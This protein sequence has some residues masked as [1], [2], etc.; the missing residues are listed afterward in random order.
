MAKRLKYDATII[1]RDDLTDTLAVFR[2]VPDRPTPRPWFTAGQYYVLGL[3]NDETRALGA[4]QRPMSIAS[5]PEAAG[6]IEFYIR[7]IAHPVSPHSFTHLLWKCKV[8]DR[9][10]MRAVAAGTFTMKDTVAVDDTRLRVLVAAGTGIA[11]F[12]SMIRSEICQKSD[13]DLARWV[14]LHGVS[15]ERD[16][17]YRPELLRVSAVHH[18]KYWATVSRPRE[19]PHWGGDVGRVE[20]FFDPERLPDLE[21]RLGLRPHGFVPDN[22]VVFICGLN[23]T[24]A[25][26]MAR[27]L[28]RAF[29]PDVDRTR[30]ALGVPAE[31]P[32]SLY[33]ERYDVDDVFSDVEG[34]QVLGPLRARMQAALTTASRRLGQI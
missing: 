20:S 30:R 29:V 25:A 15:C 18:L 3:N 2:I 9:I 8:G 33:F 32:S 17:G 16:L 12:V 31:I 28:D 6:P 21:H 4:V 10:H 5:A 34:L 11:P 7:C 24:I 26:T 19:S 13:A 14:L 22:V 23:G 27:L 1:G